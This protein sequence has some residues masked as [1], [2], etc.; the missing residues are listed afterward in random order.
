[1]MEEKPKPRARVKVRSEDQFR[2]WEKRA[3][4]LQERLQQEKESNRE[5]RA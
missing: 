1:M 5:E 4:A 3:R 2:R